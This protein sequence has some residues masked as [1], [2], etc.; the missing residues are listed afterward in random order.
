VQSTPEYADR[1]ASLQQEASKE[2]RFRA[3]SQMVES[4]AMEFSPALDLV[5]DALEQMR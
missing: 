3:K 1:A 5:L 4:V 2:L